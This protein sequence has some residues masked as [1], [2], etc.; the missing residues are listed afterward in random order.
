MAVKN[1]TQV[2]KDFERMIKEIGTP[3]RPP[4]PRKNAPGRKLG[5][6]QIKR[7]CHAIGK[8][9]INKPVGEKMAV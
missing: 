6:I 3:A 4:K 1:P 2:Q 7:L 8:K 9:K 5:Q